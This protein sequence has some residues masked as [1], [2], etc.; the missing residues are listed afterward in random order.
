MQLAR[1]EVCNHATLPGQMHITGLIHGSQLHAVADPE[2]SLGQLPPKRLC[3]PLQW[4]LFYTNAPHFGDYRSRNV[5]K[6]YSNNVLHLAELH[7][8]RAGLS[9]RLY[10]QIASTMQFFRKNTI[11]PLCLT[12]V[13]TSLSQPYFD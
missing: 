11:V 12:R 10:Y 5:G 13:R 9:P 2:G 7:D 4:R 3:R 1:S 6:K 8:L